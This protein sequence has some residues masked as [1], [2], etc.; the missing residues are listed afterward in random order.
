MMVMALAD[1]SKRIVWV[2]LAWALL[3]AAWNV[4]GVVL[5]ANGA[6]AP[7]PTAS[8]F[9]A[10][11][12]IAIG[13]GLVATFNRSAIIYAGLSIVSAAMAGAAVYNALTADP[14]LWPSEFWRYAGIMLNGVGSFA[15]GA[16]LIN[17]LRARAG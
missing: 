3:A 6:R 16:A 15:G 14:S 13:V 8:L 7:G 4:A 11:V 5:I 12:L 9:G 17:L 2:Q 1:T 10:A